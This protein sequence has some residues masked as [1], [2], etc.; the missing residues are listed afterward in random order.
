MKKIYFFKFDVSRQDLYLPY[1]YFGFKRYYEV[2]GKHIEEWQWIPPE[3]DYTHWTID[4]IV[5]E[6]V[7]HRADV[8]AFTSYMWNWSLVKAVAKRIKELLPKSILI[9]GGPHQGTTYTSPIF[10]FKKYPYFD[11]VCTPTE[12]GEWFINDCL[13]AISENNLDWNKVRF[14]YHRQGKGP[15]PNK[16][17]FN[18]PDGIIETNLDEALR[19]TRYAEDNNKRL[20][21]FF[22]T[23]RGCPYGCTYCEWSGGINTKV[24]ARELSQIQEEFNY[25]PMLQIQSIY[26]T[27]A[28][29]GILKE[30]PIKA[31][32]LADLYEASQQ[33]FFIQLGGLAKSSVKKRLAVLEPLFEVGALN[34]YQMSLQTS[35]EEALS[36]VD[37][38][39]ITV[40][41]NVEMAK[42]L[43]DKYDATIHIEFILG[44]PGYTLD[45]FYQE[46]DAIYQ[47]LSN[48][49]GVSRG[50]LLILPDSPAADPDYIKKFNLKLVPIGIEAADGEVGYDRVYSATLDPA[51]V[52]EPI[53]YIPVSC[54][55]Y[56]TD[57]WKQMN[58]MADIDVIVRIG[59]VLESFV[60]FMFYHRNMKPSE[61]FRKL[62]TALKSV[63][64]FYSKAEEYIDSI[65]RGDCAHVDWRMMSAGPNFKENA[66]ITYLYIWGQNKNQIFD[67]ILKEFE[68]DLDE[69]SKD[70]LIY[71]KETTFRFEG[72]SV[73]SSTWDWGKWEDSKDKTILPEKKSVTYITEAQPI[74]WH[75]I[76]TLQFRRIQTKILE[77]NGSLSSFKKFD[78]KF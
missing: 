3:I 30:D 58:F 19:Y 47:T 4:K 56:S 28:N 59:T 35:S 34:G 22:E 64:D 72:V 50:P 41:E 73:Y 2:Y 27:D 75:N 36:N 62:Y 65:I 32:M 53:V 24:I 18:F 12:Y 42:Y 37:R 15:S 63:E 8:Y 51:F 38:T 31:K 55:S 54:N 57:D 33:K 69:Q 67:N 10:W 7:K 49:G 39:D 9:V 20:T 17:E 29:F 78:L 13:D 16:R 45:D 26:L 40:E 21:V 70:C 43:I 74:D 25:F 68:N 52:D 5:D 23:T 1:M 60:L 77:D 6:A 76:D 11:A 66:N 14:S 44:L 71:L 46:F 48:Y 61:L